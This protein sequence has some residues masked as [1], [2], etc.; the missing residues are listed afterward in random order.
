MGM[1]VFADELYML[2]V[3]LNYTLYVSSVA[4]YVIFHAAGFTYTCAKISMVIFV[5]VC[6][7]GIKLGI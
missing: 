6:V 7:C 3:S 4:S 5:C 2:R 1:Y